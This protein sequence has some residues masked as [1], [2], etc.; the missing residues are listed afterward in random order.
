MKRW[1]LAVGALL[2][3]AWTSAQADYVLIV[4]DLGVPKSKANQPAGGPGMMM[5]GPGAGMQD[6]M[7]RMQGG[8]Q[9]G[10]RGGMMGGQ[11]GRNPF[12]G[13]EGGGGMRGGPGRFGGGGQKPSE[14]E[15]FT[16]LCLDRQTGKMLWQEVAR[17]E[18]PHEGYRQGDGTFASPSGVTDAETAKR[19]FRA[20]MRCA[21]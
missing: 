1:L 17:E 8:M 16:L 10:M 7:R 12:G 15:Q 13:E 14:V 2:G 9:G 21:G 5:G 6:M 20:R 4:Y 11:Q 18:V 19:T 3:I